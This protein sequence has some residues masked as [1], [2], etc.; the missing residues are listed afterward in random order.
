[1]KFLENKQ[2][3]IKYTLMYYISVD[4]SEGV[5]VTQIILYLV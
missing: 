4:S 1:M 3:N 5:T 2:L